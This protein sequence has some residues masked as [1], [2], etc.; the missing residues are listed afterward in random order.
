MASGAARGGSLDDGDFIVFGQVIDDDVEHETVQL[1]FGQRIG[2]LHFDGILR[3]QHVERLRQRVADAGGGDL[4]FLHGFEQ[5]GLGLGRRAVDFVGQNHVGE[6][7]AVNE[8]HLSALGGLL[9]NFRAGDVRRHEVGRELDALEFEV[10]NLGDGFDQQR[11]GQAG[12][13]GDQAMPAGKERQQN[14]LDHFPLA[15]D[16][17]AQFGFDAGAA[18]GQALDGFAFLVKVLG[19]VRW[20]GSLQVRSFSES[21][22]KR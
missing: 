11:L 5:R 15:D 9:Q 22:S 4:M 21:L 17:F 13:A 2:A 3:G 6:N 8:H 14:L 16:G 7:R 1:G 12:R 20:M 19:R 18:G 10:E